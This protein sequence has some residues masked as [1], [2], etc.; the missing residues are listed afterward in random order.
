M[1][2]LQRGIIANKAIYG[3]AQSV[4]CQMAREANLDEESLEKYFQGD[5]SHPK[6]MNDVLRQI[7]LSAQNYAHMPNT[8][9]FCDRREVFARVFKSFDVSLVSTMDAN[10][11]VAEFQQL[12]TIN[13]LSSVRNSWRKWCTAVVASCAL[14]R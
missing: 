1:E 10:V 6:V 8:I 9:K 13:N 12:Y 5:A 14:V 11:L 3:I 2:P 7:A 4:F